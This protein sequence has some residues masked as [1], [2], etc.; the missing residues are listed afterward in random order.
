MKYMS[1]CCF[2]K[3]NDIMNLMVENF[4]AV[5]RILQPAILYDEITLGQAIKTPK[6]KPN[7]RTG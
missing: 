3:T 6:T 1:A 2:L 4:G 7:T 5:L